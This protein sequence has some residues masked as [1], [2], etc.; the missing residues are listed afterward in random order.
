MLIQSLKLTELMTK[1]ICMAQ[2]FSSA[3]ESLWRLKP[4]Q[5]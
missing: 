5:V 2:I 3:L 1:E 4:V